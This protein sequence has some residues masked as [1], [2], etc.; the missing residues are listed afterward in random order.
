MFVRVDC[1]LNGI[2]IRR[3][4]VT[5]DEVIETNLFPVRE[6]SNRIGNG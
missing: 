3:A 1:F 2:N 4:S 5:N 6:F